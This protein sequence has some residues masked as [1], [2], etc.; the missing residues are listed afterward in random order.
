MMD[1]EEIMNMQALS[2]TITTMAL[3][4]AVD[5]INQVFG[6]G[7]AKIDSPLLAAVFTAQS[8]FMSNLMVAAA[9]MDESDLF[10][11]IDLDEDDDGDLDDDDDDFNLNS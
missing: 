4:N 8:Q 3:Q 9:S 6:P 11:G 10:E 5:A 1:E 2:S 7:K